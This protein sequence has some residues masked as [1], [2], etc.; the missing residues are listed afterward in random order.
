MNLIEFQ[1]TL[2]SGQSQKLQLDLGEKMA[3]KNMVLFEIF[4]SCF[5]DDINICIHRGKDGYFYRILPKTDWDTSI[6]V[7]AYNNIKV[8]LFAKCYFLKI[9]MEDREICILL[10]DS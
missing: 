1:E 7:E 3:D 2:L 6:M 5:P 9:W 10:K 8:S 4:K